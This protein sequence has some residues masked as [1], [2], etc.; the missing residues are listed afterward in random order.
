ME[1]SLLALAQKYKTDKCANGASKYGYIPYYEKHF[2]PIRNEKLKILEIGV[3]AGRGDGPPSLRLWKDYF[4]NSEIYGLD[5][6][7]ACAGHDEERVKIFI[8]N[9]GDP[10]V[11]A[12]IIDEVGQFD[13]IIDDGSHINTLTV[14][15]WEGLFDKGLVPGGLYIIEDLA[16]SYINCE[17]FDL[18][19]R[20]EGM[21]YIPEDVSFNNE[22][23]VLASFFDE[24]I[25][26]MDM[27]CTRWH[28]LHGTPEITSMTFYPMMC[29]MTKVYDGYDTQTQGFSSFEP[30]G[31]E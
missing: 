15:S 29:F 16:N 5:I 23:I 25:R 22:R 17:P 8:G 10:E 20:W 4:P 14:K 26:K 24:R 21:R 2:K 13:I 1:E 30:E 31:S 27:C 11:L 6:D 3:R 7:P 9:Q 18:R 28:K 12:K 19:N